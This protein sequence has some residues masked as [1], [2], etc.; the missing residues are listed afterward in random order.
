MP[1]RDRDEI[2]AGLV[3]L[4]HLILEVPADTIDPTARLVDDLGVDSLSLVELVLGVEEHFGVRIS[5]AEVAR[6]STLDDAAE[7]ITTAV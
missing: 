7:L 6:I 5:D 4:L 2:T 1:Q 3:E